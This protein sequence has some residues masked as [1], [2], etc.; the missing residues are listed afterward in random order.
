MKRFTSIFTAVAVALTL[1]MSVMPMT[2]F[3]AYKLT[4]NDG[5]AIPARIDV[6]ES[7]NIKVDGAKVIFIRIIKKWRQSAKKT[8]CLLR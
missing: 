1:M 3:A 8:A 4:K 5:S 7:F 6:G 2:V